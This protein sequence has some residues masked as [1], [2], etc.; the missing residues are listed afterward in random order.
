MYIKTHDIKCMACET[1]LPY[2]SSSK[3]SADSFHTLSATFSGSVSSSICHQDTASLTLPSALGCPN[4]SHQYTASW[5]Q[6]WQHRQHLQQ[7]AILDTDSNVNGPQ[8]SLLTGPSMGRN[9]TPILAVWL[10]SNICKAANKYLSSELESSEYSHRSGSK[11]CL[12]PRR[13]CFGG[14]QSL[15]GECKHAKV[16]EKQHP[17]THALPS[18]HSNLASNLARLKA[19]WNTWQILESHWTQQQVLLSSWDPYD[20]ISSTVLQHVHSLSL[21]NPQVR[22]KPPACTIF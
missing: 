19:S 4:A 8:S 6:L 22:H 17:K 14:C 21:K 10:A 9:P 16:M 11:G 7:A 2:V 12:T 13:N 5:M 15:S 18:V 3:C 1:G 20:S